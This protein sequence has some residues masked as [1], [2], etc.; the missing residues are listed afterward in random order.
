MSKNKVE[1]NA[2]IEVRNIMK[3]SDKILSKNIEEGDKEVSVYPWENV[4][5]ELNNS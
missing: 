2:V 3:K 5:D 4:I 1:E